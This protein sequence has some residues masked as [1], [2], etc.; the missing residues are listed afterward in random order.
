MPEPDRP[1]EIAFAEMRSSGVRGLLV[2]FCSHWTAMDHP[3]T[4]R[5]A[6]FPKL[7]AENHKTRSRW[8]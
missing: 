8:I 6:D 2:Y 5:L 7:L 1:H 4:G 3:A